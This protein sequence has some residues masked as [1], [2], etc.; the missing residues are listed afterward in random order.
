[1][2]KVNVSLSDL[3]REMSMN[4]RK[5]ISSNKGKL[6]YEKEANEVLKKL[7]GV[8]KL[9]S[10]I[11]R[12]N[13][14][15]YS[16]IM[17]SF[18]SKKL[19]YMLWNQNDVRAL[20][21]ILINISQLEKDSTLTEKEVRKKEKLVKNA[22]KTLREEYDIKNTDFDESDAESFLKS[23]T[24]NW[25]SWGDDDDDEWDDDEWDSWDNN[26]DR[27]GRRT[28]RAVED[29]FDNAYRRSGKRRASSL[30]DIVMSNERRS[31]YDDDDRYWDDSDD[32]DDDTDEIG[33]ED[34]LLAIKNVNDNVSKVS[35]R[36]SNLEKKSVTEVT[37]TATNTVATPTA[38]TAVPYD[39]GA[40]RIQLD[41]I[42]KFVSNMAARQ[43]AILS[44][45]AQNEKILNEILEDDDDDDDSIY[46]QGGNRVSPQ[47]ISNSW[48]T[49]ED[50]GNNGNIG[51]NNNG[52]TR[53]KGGNNG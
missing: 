42:S 16:N 34:I 17:H 43:D 23:Y 46:I 19:I 37:P 11:V 38:V 1:M 52:P 2:G 20:R 45:L 29:A 3:A 47:E 4:T 48:N 6:K 13:S 36:V 7:F 31:D 44:R 27:G 25:D 24:S 8:K 53:L 9:A 35:K 10:K 5:L 41:N 22:I 40:I 32:D 30:R 21:S 26:W 28:F 14:Y 18:E 12:M 49:P 51:S 15:N 50:N 33:M 39:D